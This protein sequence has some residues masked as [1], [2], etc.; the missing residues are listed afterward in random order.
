MQ[1]STVL[2][3]ETGEI[4]LEDKNDKGNCLPESR[5]CGYWEF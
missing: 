2:W 1:S 3:K 5:W 4:V